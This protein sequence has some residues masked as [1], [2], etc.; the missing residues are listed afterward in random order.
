MLTAKVHLYAGDTNIFPF[1]IHAVDELQT[2][3]K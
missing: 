2:A 3:F 1:P